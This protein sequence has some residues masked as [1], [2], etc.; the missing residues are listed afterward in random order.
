[1]ELSTDQRSRTEGLF[2]AMKAE[3]LPLG[4]KLLEQKADLDRQFAG[5]TVTSASL[6]ASNYSNRR[7]AGRAS[8]NPP[9]VPSIDR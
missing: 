8:R 4:S 2:N 1:V 6:K 3:A 7:D 5:R 9:Q